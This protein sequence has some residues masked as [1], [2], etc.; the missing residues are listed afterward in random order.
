M[1]IKIT[2]IKPDFFDALAALQYDCF[3]HIPA[4][5]YFDQ[6]HFESHFKL[7]PEGSFVALD[8]NQVVGFASG[9]FCDLDL[10]HPGHKLMESTGQGFYT[11][12]NPDGKFYYAVDL[13]VH[14]QY[15]KSGIGS[16]F[17][18]LR[19]ALVEKYNKQGIVA[20]AVPVGY[21]KFQKVLSPGEYL[22]KVASHE[23]YDATLSFQLKNGFKIL[24]LL[25][26]YVENEFNNSAALI[27]WAN[28]KFTV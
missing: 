10:N 22:K 11:T 26:N 23:I 18:N 27:Y 16:Q 25:S 24:S 5:E 21:S 12:H 28:P 2:Q 7:F 14:P 6:R 4:S 3:P 8:D 13:G 9:L 15:R 19:K 17:Y 20:G 1:A